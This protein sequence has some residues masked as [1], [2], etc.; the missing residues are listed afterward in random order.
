VASA[1]SSLRPPRVNSVCM[2]WPIKSFY[3]QWHP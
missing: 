3:R 1:A 2:G